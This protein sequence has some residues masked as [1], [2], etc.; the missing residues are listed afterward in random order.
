MV[1]NFYMFSGKGSMN[2]KTIREWRYFLS[3]SELFFFRD[4]FSWEPSESFQGGSEG[5]FARFWARVDINGRDIADGSQFRV[6]E[7]VFHIGPPRM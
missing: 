1:L 2:P 4:I 6:G 3:P 7:E 5:I